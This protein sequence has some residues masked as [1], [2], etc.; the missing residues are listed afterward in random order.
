M[1]TPRKVGG[2]RDSSLRA[3]M[4]RPGSASMSER[5]STFGSLAD[6]NVST[7]MI[8]VGGVENHEREDDIA[9]LFVVCDLQ[10][11]ALRDT[12]VCISR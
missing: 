9:K 3:S 8:W 2:S 4:A 1:A 11:C 7:D 6:S 10:S 12:A 5:H